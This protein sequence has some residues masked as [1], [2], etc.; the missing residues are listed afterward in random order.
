[1]NELSQGTHQENTALWKDI[2]LKY[3]NP[4][5]PRALWQIVNTI[6]PYAFLWYLIYRSLAISWWL[7]I[8]LAV[9]AGAFLVRGIYYF[10]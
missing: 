1:M 6:V 4:S 5:L 7:V 8:P 9:L 2:V 10:P 3:Q